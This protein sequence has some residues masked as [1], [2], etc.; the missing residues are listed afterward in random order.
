MLSRERGFQVTAAIAITV[1]L[2][3][4]SLNFSDSHVAAYIG[5]FKLSNSFFAQSAMSRGDIIA[6]AKAW[7]DVPVPYDEGS[8][9]Q[10][11]RED[12][13]GFVSMAWQLSKSLTTYTLPTVS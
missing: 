9:Y 7:V 12:C 2:I 10:G 11:Y 8:L 4:I 13:S 5:S 6:R 1:S 3:L